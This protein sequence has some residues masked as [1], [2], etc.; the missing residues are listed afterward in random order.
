MKQHIKK[1]FHHASMLHPRNARLVQYTQVYK[2]NSPHKQH[3]RQK[4]HDYLNRCREGL[5][6]NS[7]ALYMKT[8]NK[9][10]I[11]GMYL[12]IIKA[13]YDKLT[14]IVILNEQKLEAFPFK[15]GTSKGCPSHHF[16]SI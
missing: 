16:Y 13:I 3:Q 2:C 12:K 15:S 9:I 8:L 4:P 6:Q 5:Q 11:D 14:A 7:T 10:G 1:L